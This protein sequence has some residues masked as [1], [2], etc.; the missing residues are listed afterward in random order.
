MRNRLLVPVVGAILLVMLFLGSVAYI[1]AQVEAEIETYESLLLARDDIQVVQFDYNRAFWGGQ[2]TY[3]LSWLESQGS[4]LMMT[5][6]QSGFFGN[7][8]SAKGV[9]DVDHGPWLGQDGFGLARFMLD[10][11]L[12]EQWRTVL[13]QYPVN[14]PVIAV[15]GIIKFNGYLQAIAS[16]ADYDGR[17]ETNLQVADLL[18]NGLQMTLDINDEFSLFGVGISS[19]VVALDMPNI[20]MVRGE[21]ILLTNDLRIN[22]G[23]WEN[24]FDVAMQLFQLQGSGISVEQQGFRFLAGIHGDG[25]L[26][27]VS[28]SKVTDLVL[29]STL[30][31]LSIDGSSGVSSGLFNLNGLSI[32]ADMSQD[33]SSAILSNSR[34]DLDHLQISIPQDNV[35][36]TIDGLKSTGSVERV[37]DTI[38]NYLSGD[39]QQLSVDG[40]LIGGAEMEMSLKGVNVDSYAVLTN[41][42]E[43]G[44][45]F[46]MPQ[47]GQQEIESALNDLVHDQITISLDRLV[48]M[49]P[50]EEDLV[51]TMSLT[52]EGSPQ[53]NATSYEAI[54]QAIRLD[55]NI[56]ASISAIEGAINNANLDLQVQRELVAWLQQMY[57][58]PF[59]TVSNDSVSSTMQIQQGELLVNGVP[60]I[61]TSQLLALV[62]G[63]FAGGGS[64]YTAAQCVSV[65]MGGAAMAYSSD[66]LY[67]PKTRDVLAGGAVDLG[68]CSTLPGQGFLKASPDLTLDFTENSA[69]RSLE[70]RTDSEC[71]SVLLV[72]NSEAGWHYDDDSNGNSD[73]M[74]RIN[75]AQNGRYH[76]WVGTYYPE[77]SC[78]SVLSIETFNN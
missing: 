51:A 27:D 30:D 6:G 41:Y 11:E 14:S 77:P 7:G 61:Q 35:N 40:S 33:D 69:A 71:D 15:T 20:M 72:N 29:E 1:G 67:T 63:L 64:M 25:Q 17:V 57:Q 31:S 38:E 16:V 23:G 65:G 21:E 32:L 44:T 36:F 60:L 78:S 37:G 22:G 2:L 13:P 42:G 58:M 8:T 68:Q 49:L 74:L 26:S 45:S 50:D 39:L 12:P 59:V 56:R 53:I 70:F 9:I 47:A 43:S 62:E 55:S 73:A 48:F 28:R 3:E 75:N 10:A 46:V 52:Y 34:F 18:L 24:E 19:G 76:V 66:D 4:P 54:V 5:L